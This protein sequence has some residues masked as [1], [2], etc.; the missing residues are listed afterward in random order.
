[1]IMQKERVINFGLHLTL[2]GYGG[3]FEKLNDR[4]L[5]LKCLNELP[6]KINMHKL[7]PPVVYFAK[8]GNPK[9]SGGWSGIVVIEESHISCH[10]FPHRNFVSIDVY[11]CSDVLDKDFI[12]KY[13]TEIFELKDLEINFL[14]R[15]TRFPAHDLA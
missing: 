11:T 3:S 2:D 15:G 8:G 7:A 6:E 5:V 14:H 10:T 13:F 1:M 4:E 9:D 12:T